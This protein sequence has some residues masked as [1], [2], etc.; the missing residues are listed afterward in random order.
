[1]K[2]SS[3]AQRPL[4]IA[5]LYGALAGCTVLQPQ[6]AEELKVDSLTLRG[7]LTRGVV[8]A[9]FCLHLRYTNAFWV[10]Y[11][12][13]VTEAWVTDGSCA[14]QGARRAVDAVRLGWW[15]DG[16]TVQLNRQCLRAEGCRVSE[17]NLV[18]GRHIRCASAV[19]QEGNQTA[20][21]TTNHNA[22]H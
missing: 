11:S 10:A 2:L 17:Q 4:V 16:D 3:L 5:L 8:A 22:C 21:L 7:E 13:A 12:D 15:Q 19:A 14:S 9:P 1:M 20:F 6:S 18:V